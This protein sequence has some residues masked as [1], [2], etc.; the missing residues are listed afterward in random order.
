MIQQTLPEG[1]VEDV[2]FD[3]ALPKELREDEK[4]DP[5]SPYGFNGD[6]KEI[7]KGATAKTLEEL[8]KPRTR[9]KLEPIEGVKEGVGTTPTAVT[10]SPA[11]IAAKKMQK[12]KYRIN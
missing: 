2:S 8:L 4:G 1:V 5:V 10:F 6:G 3:P 11:M 12:K 7:P 9:E